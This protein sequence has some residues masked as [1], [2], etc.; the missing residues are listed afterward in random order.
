MIICPLLK[1]GISIM[2]GY[3]KTAKEQP[4]AASVS[5]VLA[6]LT[7]PGSWDFRGREKAPG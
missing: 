3:E 1:R 7:L 4:V 2:W 6:D 5:A